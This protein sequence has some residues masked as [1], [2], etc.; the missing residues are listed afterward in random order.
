MYHEIERSDSSLS[1]ADR[2]ALEIYA[3]VCDLRLKH[4]L[5]SE[6]ERLPDTSDDSAA[7]KLY[8]L[9]EI[10]RNEGDQAGHAAILQQMEQVSA[11]PLAG[12]GAVLRWQHVPD[13]AQPAAGN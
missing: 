6:A 12:G 1:Q 7:L 9:A 11:Q 8:I 5:R 4:L 2:N 3:A 13:Q 10:S